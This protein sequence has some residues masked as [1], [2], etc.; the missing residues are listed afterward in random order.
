MIEKNVPWFCQSLP[1]WGEIDQPSMQKLNCLAREKGWEAALHQVAP[2]LSNYV[3]SPSRTNWTTLLPLKP[4]W[5]ALDIG[6]GWG[7]NAFPLSQRLKHVVALEAV[8]ERAEFMEIRRLQTA[9]NN[10]Q[11]VAAS[12]HEMPLPSERFNLVVMNGILEWV[13]ISAQG[14]PGRVQKD[15]L[16][17]VHDLLDQDGWLYLG[18]ENRFSFEVFL[19]EQ[20]DSG[21]PFA[22]LMP[23]KM[24]DLYMHW[25]SPRH[26]RTHDAMT[27]YR[28][29]TYSY[30]GYKR[31]LERCGFKDFKA[32]GTYS[33]NRPKQLYNLENASELKP[34]REDRAPASGRKKLLHFLASKPAFRTLL[35]L[36]SPAFCIVARK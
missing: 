27:S 16:R 29:Y 12:I 2:Q 18:I 5:T 26:N 4:D 1:Y 20:D 21:M 34:Y 25:L 36:F 33:Y 35:R 9:K 23:R 10:L 17:R 7:S 32:W 13:A 14:D 30:W 3:T 24:A 6:A 8:L 28:T 15:I 19:G 22:S 11:V 31:L